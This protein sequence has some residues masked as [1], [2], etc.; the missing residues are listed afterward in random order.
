MVPFG[1]MLVL[2]A[3]VMVLLAL[4]NATAA[5]WL[6][7]LGAVAI[8]IAD[9]FVRPVFM[10]GSSRLPLV[11]VLLGIVGGLETFG[12]LGLFLGPTLLAVMVAV[13]RQMAG[14]RGS[15]PPLIG[16]ALDLE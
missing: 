3:V 14:Q 2:A 5:L 12:V 6:G 8:F 9:H 10:S 4:G 13:W 1:A 16:S 11:V 7:I 15:D